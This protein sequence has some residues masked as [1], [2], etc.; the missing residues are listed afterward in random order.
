[1]RDIDLIY[2]LDILYHELDS[3]EKEL[4]HT[5]ERVE[6]IKRNDEIR[7]YQLEL[8]NLYKITDA[9]HIEQRKKET[10]LNDLKYKLV[11][12]KDSFEKT[13]IKDNRQYEH[14]VSS[15]EELEKKIDA[16]ELEIIDIMMNEDKLD[17]L[18]EKNK[19]KID[20]ISKEIAE[21]IINYD[22]KIIDLEKEIEDLSNSI[23]IQK[24]RISVENLTKYEKIKTK[25]KKAVAIVKNRAC[26]SCGMILPTSHFDLLQKND[27][28]L[29][30][31]NCGS[32]LYYQKE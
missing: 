1:M 15:I 7:S 14:F 20:E 10:Q 17:D 6:I 30:C 4:Q 32:I 28:I 3:K 9:K 19:N 2:Q 23:F 27:D 11:N 12:L 16:L 24:N 21:L 8:E 29:I 13:I 25:K 5:K 18:I 26:T 31:E 22:L